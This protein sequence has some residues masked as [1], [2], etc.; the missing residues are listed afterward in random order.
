M[1]QRLEILLQ[2]FNALLSPKSNTHSCRNIYWLE[3][4]SGCACEVQ[5]ENEGPSRPIHITCRDLDAHPL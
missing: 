1:R 5:Q 3:Q 2:S 4:Q